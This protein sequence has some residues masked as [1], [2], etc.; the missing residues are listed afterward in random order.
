MSATYNQGHDILR[1]FDTLPD[2]MFT[3]SETKRDYM[4]YTSDFTSSESA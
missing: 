4:V 3:T 1:I 2:F